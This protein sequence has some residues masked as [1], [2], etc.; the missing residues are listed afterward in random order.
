LG[1]RRALL[2]IKREITPLLMKF[3]SKIG[4]YSLE[5]KARPI[6]NASQFNV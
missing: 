3:F 1:T 6:A 2:G 5:I 4:Q